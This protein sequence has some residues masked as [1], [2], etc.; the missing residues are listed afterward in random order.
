MDYQKTQ[1]W[2]YDDVS[3]FEEDEG[4]GFSFRERRIKRLENKLR[5]RLLKEKERQLREALLVT[6]Y[7][8]Q[9]YKANVRKLKGEV[10]DSHQVERSRKMNRRAKQMES[11]ASYETA[12]GKYELARKETYAA[13]A[14][15]KRSKLENKRYSKETRRFRTLVDS[16]RERTKYVPMYRDRSFYYGGNWNKNKG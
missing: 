5:K 13:K 9:S 7:N 3:D 10:K 12:R 2:T 11:R 6:D 16:N 1:Y 4:K 8:R 14:A 15:R